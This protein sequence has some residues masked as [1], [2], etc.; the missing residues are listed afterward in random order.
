MPK[1]EKITVNGEVIDKLPAGNYKVK[2]R[3]ID[4]EVICKA[5]GKMRIK[6]IG[7]IE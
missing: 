7:I 4:V 3:D 6:H 1:Q 5:K 2:P